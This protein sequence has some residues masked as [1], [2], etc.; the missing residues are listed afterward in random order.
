MDIKMNLQEV[1]SL[2][3]LN[4]VLIIFHKILNFV[5]ILLIVVA[6]LYNRSF[7]TQL[8]F[9]RQFIEWGTVNLRI[10]APLHITSTR[11]EEEYRVVLCLLS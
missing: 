3:I 6:F 8:L 2:I 5:V 9:T 10:W 4:D 1:L 11:V 7:Y